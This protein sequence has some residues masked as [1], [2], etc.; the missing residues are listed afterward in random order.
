MN[1]DGFI[2]SEK[3]LWFKEI[4]FLIF[5]DVESIKYSSPVDILLSVFVKRKLDKKVILLSE[6][7]N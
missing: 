3:L 2:K 6:S 4:T 7:K 5:I 1:E